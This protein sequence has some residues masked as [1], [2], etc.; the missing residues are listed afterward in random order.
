MT[1]GSDADAAARRTWVLGK[2]R[3]CVMVSFFVHS[4][5]NG[6]TRR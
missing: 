6:L 4:A 3:L 1:A 5:V 2:N